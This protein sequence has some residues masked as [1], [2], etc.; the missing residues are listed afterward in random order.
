MGLRVRELFLRSSPRKR[1]PKGQTY[2]LTMKDWVPACAGTNG[3]GGSDASHRLEPRA[4]MNLTLRQHRRLRAE[5]LDDAAHERPRRRR[6]DE[7]RRLPVARRVLETL[8]HQR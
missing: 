1:G 7:H 4:R 2:G 3:E 8:A 5:A 6:G